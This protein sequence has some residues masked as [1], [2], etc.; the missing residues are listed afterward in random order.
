M[1]VDSS[2]DCWFGASND[3]LLHYDGST[4]TTVDS[5][6][7][8]RSMA[9]DSAGVITVGGDWSGTSNNPGSVPVRYIG[10]YDTVAETW[11]TL[12]DAAGPV[13]SLAVKGDNST[14]YV[15]ASAGAGA[16]AIQ[17]WTGTGF[18]TLG[19]VDTLGGTVQNV[20]SMAYD[21]DNNR[22]YVGGNFES[23]EGNTGLKYVAYY[24]FTT[25]QWN[26]IEVDLQSQISELKAISYYSPDTS[27][28]FGYENTAGVP[29]ITI[30]QN[31]AVSNTGTATANPSITMAGPGAVTK[32]T[33]VTTGAKIEFSGLTLASGET[34]TIDLSPGA[35]SISTTLRSSLLNLL[36]SDSNLSTFSLLPGSNTISLQTATTIS[37]T[38]SWYDTHWSIYGAQ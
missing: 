28:V 38:I 25:G 12:S 8:V 13:F 15:G 3:T 4:I 31:T 36:T 24:D 29:S 19:V 26:D 10:Q 7:D 37:G 14:V 18:E 5:E 11:G 35:K 33:N 23:L 34:M 21:A 17:T 32:I 9:I 20:N 22:L 1:V 27:V 6:N 16:G 30:P 2:D